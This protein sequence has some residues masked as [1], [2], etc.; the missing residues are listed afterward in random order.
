MLHSYVFCVTWPGLETP[1]WFFSHFRNEHSKLLRFLQDILNSTESSYF[2]VHLP[3]TAVLV[4]SMYERSVLLL[5][6]ALL[7]VTLVYRFLW[8]YSFSTRY[9]IPQTTC[10]SQLQ[11]NS[12]FNLLGMTMSNMF[13]FHFYPSH[14]FNLSPAG[15]HHAPADWKFNI[16]FCWKTIFE[17]AVPQFLL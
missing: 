9:H 10:M 11:V 16:Y 3:T 14:A 1:L 8:E 15:T 17:L 13:V 12:V 2:G 6:K 5:F 7:S 4:L